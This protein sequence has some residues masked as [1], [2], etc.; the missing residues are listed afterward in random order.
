MINPKVS[1]IIPIF[2]A[3]AFLN[4]CIESIFSQSYHNIELILVNDG[5]SDRSIDICK[6][7]ADK[8]SRIV[9][10]DIPNGGASH[11]R[12]I[13]LDCVSGDF[14]WFVDADDWVDANALEGL[15]PEMKDDI[16]FFGFKRIFSDRTEVCQISQRS[17]F[18]ISDI[19]E[20]LSSLFKSKD[21]YFGFTWNKLFRKDIII[22]HNIRF[23]ETLIIKEDEVFTL[24]YCKHIK[25]ISISSKTPYNYRILGDSVSH[26][27]GRK[28]KYAP[29][30][31]YCR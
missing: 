5:S 16:L 28:K 23:N 22:N 7:Y 15:I 29:T 27:R 11:A 31:I 25:N 18:H 1:I 30:C 19:D 6:D 24:E 3:E 8:D 10:K 9:V 12:N 14:I 4:K 17:N 2:N 13:G 21:A 26:S 20:W